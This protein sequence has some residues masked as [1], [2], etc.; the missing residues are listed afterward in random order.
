MDQ[1]TILEILGSGSSELEALKENLEQLTGFIVLVET[2]DKLPQ[3]DRRVSEDGLSLYHAISKEKDMATLEAALG[4]F[5]GDPI[6]RSG[7]PLSAD[8]ADNLTIRYLGGVK[9]DQTLFLKKIG[10]SE[11]YGALFPWQRKSDVITVHLGLYNPVMSEDDYN[12]LEKLVTETIT[13]RVSEEVESGL[14]GQVQGIS[15]PSFLQMSEMEGSTCSLRISSGDNTGMLHLLNGNMIDAETDELKHKDAAYAILSWDNPVIEI[16]KAAGRTKNEIKLPLMHL[17]MDGMRRKDQQEFEKDASPKKEKEKTTQKK[18]TKSPARKEPAITEAP[19]ETTPQKIEKKASPPVPKPEMSKTTVEI[20]KTEATPEKERLDKRS[21]KPVEER[22][23]EPQGKKHKAED[24]I[25]DALIQKDVSRP[26]K[27]Q[28]VNKAASGLKPKKKFPMTM[29]AGLAIVVLCVAG[30]F[31][32]QGMSGDSGANDYQR[33]MKKVEKLTDADSQEKLLMDFINT[34]EPGEDTA[35]AEMKLEEIWLQN[36][37]ANYQK[38]IDA[39]NKLPIDPTFEKKAGE[40]Y[41]R[42]LE[43]YPNTRHAEDIQ[44]AVS[45]ISGLS[46]DIVFSNLRNLGGKNYVQKIDLYKNYLSLYPQ[47]KHRDSVKQMFS[48]TLGESY[49]NFKREISVCEREAKWDTCLTIC[50][51]YLTTFSAYL[52]TDEIQTIRNR[53]MMEK[54]YHILQTRVAGVDDDSAR[55]LYMAYMTA[56]PDSSN[57][58]AIQ[59]NL[60]RMDLDITAGRQWA[61]LKKSTQSSSLSLQEKI[62]RI[63]KYIS[64][65]NTSRYAAEAREILKSLRKEADIRSAEREKS[66]KSLTAGEKAKKEAKE[67]YALL[68][69]RKTE[70]D[71]VQREKKKVIMSLDKTEGRFVLSGDS[72]V[73]DQKTGLLWGLLDSQR[74]LGTC[75]DHRTARRYVKEIRYSGHDDWRLPTSAELA[76]IY[77]N[78][79]YFPDSGAEWYW[80]SEIFAKG[81]SYIVNTVTAKQET[82]FKKVSQD[83][84]ACGSV[85]AVRP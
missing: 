73:M 83:V 47:G 6:K 81:Y 17:L 59:E 54:D 23:S 24:T 51:D 26:R 18:K 74:E 28:R 1:D 68:V 29:V 42:F 38:T 15:L 22:P 7:E 35:R 12:K 3:M 49:M 32:Y 57:N 62:D 37:E 31:I 41:T 27:P 39:V 85:R 20:D 16:L 33:L 76:G 40:L 77:K 70:Q 43:K 55:R 53:I 5:F 64:R 30:F 78:K 36:E 4:S 84:E 82:V 66:I 80:T 2:L 52:D 8:L 45:E 25:D 44:L 79:P 48:E 69:K 65:N 9:E 10:Q 34:H 19:I 13:Q 72:S 71:R 67:R 11:L 46:E 14:A 60:Q 75:M 56:Y 61:S 58:K 50:D 63:E 21:D